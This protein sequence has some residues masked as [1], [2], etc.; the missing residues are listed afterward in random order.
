MSRVERGGRKEG[1]ELAKRWTDLTIIYVK[2]D[3]LQG[4]GGQAVLKER[5]NQWSGA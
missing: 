2:E 5:G 3:R 1:R 4:G